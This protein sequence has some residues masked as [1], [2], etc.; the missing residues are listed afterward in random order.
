MFNLEEDP[1]IVIYFFSILTVVFYRSTI[2]Y[3]RYESFCIIPDK[4]LLFILIP[5]PHHTSIA[6][7]FPPKIYTCE[8]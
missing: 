3:Y 6:N 5:N 1:E 7:V 8:T 2:A 4:I